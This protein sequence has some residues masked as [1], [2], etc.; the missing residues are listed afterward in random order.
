MT[1][2]T[3]TTYDFT[4]YITDSHN[5]RYIAA[6]HGI[7]PTMLA[8]QF[9]DKVFESN[10][11]IS[12]L[13]CGCFDSKERALAFVEQVTDS[14]LILAIPTIDYS[15]VITLSIS[16]NGDQWVLTDYENDSTAYT[17]FESL[18][19]LPFAAH[20][21]GSICAGEEWDELAQFKPTTSLNDSPRHVVVMKATV[22]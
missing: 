17:T 1:S 14:P 19:Q 21:F 8:K 16:H 12:P 20:S 3:T 5:P 15:N 11:C 6:I 13:F 18:D 2:A 22:V 4:Q 9:I 7:L 10:W